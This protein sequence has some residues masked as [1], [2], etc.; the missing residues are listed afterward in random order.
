[1][2]ARSPAPIPWNADSLYSYLRQGF[3]PDHGSARGP[4]AEVV[5]NLSS[6]SESDVRA[7]ATYMVSVFGA[8]APDQKNRGE[9]VLAQAKSP[10]PV[11]LPP[12]STPR[13]L[14]S[15]RRPARPATRPAARLPYGGVNLA[16]STAINGPDPR[17]AVNI[18]L[19][20]IR[21]V[22]GER[23]PI[24]PGFA[25]T[26]NDEQIV[27]AA[28]ISC[29]PGSATSRHGPALRR[30]STVARRTQT[31]FLQTSPGPHNASADPTQRDKP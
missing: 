28:A 8:P 30:P 2:N 15:S 16:L 23:S 19:S 29:A 18:V 7:I 26:M 22:D 17:N 9:A 3:D 11:T 20:G 21:P 12:I 1:M 5:S 4:M 24:M 13:A 6:V 10:P 14:R 25:A 27:G 31:V